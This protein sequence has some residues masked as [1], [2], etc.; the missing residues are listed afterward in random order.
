[1]FR[2]IRPLIAKSTKGLHRL[3]RGPS[4]KEWTKKFS[5]PTVPQTITP[6]IRADLERR[7]YIVESDDYIRGFYGPRVIAA[8]KPMPEKG[9]KEWLE[10]SGKIKGELQTKKIE[11]IKIAANCIGLLMLCAPV[12][13][14]VIAA[15]MIMPVLII[16]FLF[17]AL[18][19]FL[20][21]L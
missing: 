12:I 16:A 2:R 15:V 5:K 10:E 20:V 21:S 9:Y 8:M 13:V 14:V 3:W 18:A 7:E 11:E 4:D 1:M 19:L 17:L 6:T